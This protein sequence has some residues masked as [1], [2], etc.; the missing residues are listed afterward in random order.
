MMRA[1]VGV[2]HYPVTPGKQNTCVMEASVFAILK[3][4]LPHFM[5]RTSERV[6]PGASTIARKSA[7]P[8][9]PYICR[10]IVFKRLICPSTCPL[11]QLTFRPCWD[12]LVIFA[13]P[14]KTT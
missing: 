10:L 6:H 2:H 3:M 13:K 11:L 4:A 5:W 9:R 12:R 8:A 14:P 7:N 1:G